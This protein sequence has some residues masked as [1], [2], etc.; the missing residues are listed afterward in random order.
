LSSKIKAAI[1]E[2]LAP[3]E[4]ASNAKFFVN[5]KDFQPGSVVVNFR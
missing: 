3:L 1:E 4:S 2:I 5:I